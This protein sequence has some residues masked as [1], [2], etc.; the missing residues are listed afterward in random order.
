MLCC[1]YMPSVALAQALESA[2]SSD[3]KDDDVSAGG[4]EKKSGV[5]KKS[6]N[7]LKEWREKCEAL[8]KELKEEREK[9]SQRRG[10]IKG[11]LDWSEE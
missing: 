9:H 3:G 6:T 1:P 11:D 2:K 8:E 5:R 7:S 10:S 4:P